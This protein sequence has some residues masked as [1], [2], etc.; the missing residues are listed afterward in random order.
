[1]ACSYKNQVGIRLHSTF[2]GSP[3]TIK[4]FLYMAVAVFLQK[5]N[6]FQPISNHVTALGTGESGNQTA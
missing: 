1:M 3:E 5:N 6:I 2:A 4:N